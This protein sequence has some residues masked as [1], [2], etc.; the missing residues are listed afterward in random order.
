MTAWS[1]RRNLNAKERRHAAAVGKRY[2]KA[3]ASLSKARDQINELIRTYDGVVT[4]EELSLALD[5]DR[6]IIREA[7]LRLGLPKLQRRK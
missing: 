6:N 3:V 5:V 2:N 7:K 1:T 4:Q